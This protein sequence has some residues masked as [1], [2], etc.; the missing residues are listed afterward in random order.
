MRRLVAIAT[1]VAGMLIWPR[2]S[3]AQRDDGRT[4]RA[5]VGAGERPAAKRTV[6]LADAL[7]H[8]ERS[9][10]LLA[11]AQARLGLGNAAREGA[12]PL[13][14]DNPN[15]ELGLGPRSGP[16]GQSSIDTHVRVQ[17]R[18]EVAG[19]RG[20]R[21]DA[22]GR[23]GA[24]EEERLA[25]ARFA[26]R[27][28]VRAAF[29]E[30]LLARERAVSARE[31]EAIQARILDIARARLRAG[32]IGPLGVRLAEGDLAQV[33]QAQIEAE[34]RET[35]TRLRLAA[36][37]GL[38]TDPLPD[39][40]GDLPEPSAPLPADALLE[41]ARAAQP[42]RRVALAEL[43]ERE[44]RMALASREARPTPTVGFEY[45]REDSSQNIWLA[46]IGIPL[47]LFQ[48]N[49]GGRALARAES[50][51]ARAELDAL[52]RALPARIR[53]LAATADAA[54]RRVALYRRDVLPRLRENLELLGRAFE[55]GEIDAL[56]VSGARARLLDVGR[57]ALDAYG[58]YLRAMADLAAETGVEWPGR[59]RP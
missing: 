50:D 5:P 15:V 44:S 37:A 36:V 6:S 41:R 19:Q 38:P 25:S 32:D 26:L 10:P 16:G 35:G 31:A 46:T 27:T 11:P 53:S 34:A 30:A 20:A 59:T 39:L 24:L 57:A 23:L 49:Q 48:R 33:A 2:L 56:E 42:T 47:P 12:E 17:Q 18:I 43:A 58:E 14:R 54:A 8:A 52:D 21:L 51:I 1:L 40:A 29:Y 3:A 22:A 28:V 55:L 7:A 45:A 13:L 4:E 9:S